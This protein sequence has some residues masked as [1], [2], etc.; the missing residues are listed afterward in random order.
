MTIIQPSNVN[1][2]TKMRNV[3]VRKVQ[4]ERKPLGS[5]P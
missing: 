5:V 3:D 4:T 2:T 1:R